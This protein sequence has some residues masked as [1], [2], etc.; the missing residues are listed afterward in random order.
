MSW[1]LFSGNRLVLLLELDGLCSC[2]QVDLQEFQAT[3]GILRFNLGFAV[4]IF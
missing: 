1:H 2:C 3:L 4:N